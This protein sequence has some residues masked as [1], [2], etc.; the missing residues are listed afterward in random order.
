MAQV[1]NGF[2]GSLGN[3]IMAGPI[4]AVIRPV[5]LGAALGGG[6]AAAPAGCGGPSNQFP[7]GNIPPLSGQDGGLNNTGPQGQF[8]HCMPPQRSLTLLVDG[9]GAVFGNPPMTQVA[10]SLAISVNRQSIRFPGSGGAGGDGGAGGSAPDAGVSVGSDGWIH[11]T[12]D[13][14]WASMRIPTPTQPITGQEALMIADRVNGDPISQLL[15]PNPNGMGN[16]LWSDQFSVF[17]GA[18]A[19]TM[20][21]DSNHD[22]INDKDQLGF[23]YFIDGAVNPSNC[24]VSLTIRSRARRTGVLGPVLDR[25]VFP[26]YTDGRNDPDFS[27]EFVTIHQ[28]GLSVP[29]S[30]PMIIPQTD[31]ADGRRRTQT[32]TVCNGNCDDVGDAASNPQEMFMTLIVEPRAD[33]GAP[34]DGGTHADAGHDGGDGGIPPLPGPDGGTPDGGAPHDAASGG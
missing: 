34:E 23:L 8:D 10:G 1:F 22:G 31:G 24:D 32:V 27:D 15:R 16:I 28:T 18:D 30:N 9:Q 29:Q 13:G 5:V 33:A 17:A 14:E 26:Q 20:T 12:A 11:F 19:G 2:L 21:N 6:F 3:R 7:D 4:G 25:F